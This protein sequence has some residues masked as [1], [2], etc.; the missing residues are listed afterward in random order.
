[1]TDAN[2]K[3][4]V[5]KRA[6]QLKDALGNMD[7]ATA[8]RR[9][10]MMQDKPEEYLFPVQK[11]SISEREIYID[12]AYHEDLE[13][14]LATIKHPEI[15][16]TEFSNHVLFTGLPGTGKTHLAKYIATIT[17]ADFVPVKGFPNPGSVTILFEEARRRAKDKAQIIFMD[18]VDQYGSRDDIGGDSSKVT[19]LGRL[20]QEMDSTDSNYNIT[21]IANT[22][23]PRGVDPAL[24][25]EGGRIG[26]EVEF[27]SLSPAGRYEVLKIMANN[28]SEKELAVISPNKKGHK[29][30]IDDKLLKE[31][32]EISHG[33]TNGDLK[34]LLSE[35]FLTAYI[36]KER[37][38]VKDKDVNSAL[39]KVR[40]SAL[41][42]LPMQS[43]RRTLEQLKGLDPHIMMCLDYIGKDFNHE[44]PG[45]TLLFY[46][47][48]GLGKSALAE[49]IAKH[50]GINYLV[51]QGSQL[52][53]SL[54][55]STDDAID[56]I[57]TRAEQH[58]PTLLLW[59]EF[60]ALF[61]TKGIMGYKDTWTG[62]FQ[63]R[64]TYLP[65]GVIMIA[66]TKD[67]TML[68]DA[69]VERFEKLVPFGY[70]DEKAL[71]EMWKHYLTGLDGDIDYARL[72]SLSKGLSGR[73]VERQATALRSYSHLFKRV[74][75]P[76]V[77]KMIEYAR[78]VDPSMPR[79]DLSQY[80][81]LIG[82][83]KGE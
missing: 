54:L 62:R 38:D 13:K 7:A 39:K 48:S 18:E 14:I 57:I 44:S 10:A 55:G 46:G 65:E 30:S 58:R 74:T 4:E 23:R 33:Y 24:R 76:M 36:D 59:D 12:Q 77:E 21:I 19:L 69:T 20:L 75:Q 6:D 2:G 68:M 45:K 47:D 43:P 61:Q 71:G 52:M 22:N 72:G 42:D 82:A 32:A 83:A 53:N 49:A 11:A 8:A 56:L 37:Y 35:A 51:V 29:F 80:V 25:R 26:R 41:R 27:H 81:A 15:L 40:P 3:T 67:P 1:M 60:Q 16:G 50:Y 70:A 31:L 63:S 9:F 73:A 5:D 34:G 64:M 66:T 17:E 79:D 28:L 78:T